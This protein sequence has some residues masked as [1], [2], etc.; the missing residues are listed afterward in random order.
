[1]CI[2]PLRST[3]FVAKLFPLHGNEFFF[4]FLVLVGRLRSCGE[5]VAMELAR[6]H[7]GAS[8]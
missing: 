7:T 1:M 3:F 2:L 5:A 8:T 6:K 4:F